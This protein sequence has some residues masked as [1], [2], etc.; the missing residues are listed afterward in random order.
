[1]QSSISS[2]PDSNNE[3]IVRMKKEIQLLQNLV[4]DLTKNKIAERVSEELRRTQQHLPSRLQG[5]VHE[6]TGVHNSTN[7]TTEL[8]SE[9]LRQTQGIPLTQ[10]WAYDDYFTKEKIAECDTE[11]LRRVQLPYKLP[12]QCQAS[13]YESMGMYMEATNLPDLVI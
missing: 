4:H 8:G 9:E 13:E 3:V 6:R 5:R 1:M 10:R 12:F 2:D 11:E 7:K